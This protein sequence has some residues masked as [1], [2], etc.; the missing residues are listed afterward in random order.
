VR[1]NS[2]G[3]RYAAILC[4]AAALMI[5]APFSAI[6]MVGTLVLIEMTAGITEAPMTR[7]A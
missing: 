6:M 4:C 5:A 1:I 2:T 7:S 3:L